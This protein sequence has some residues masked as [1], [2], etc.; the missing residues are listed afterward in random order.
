MLEAAPVE[1]NQV[2]FK[3]FLSMHLSSANIAALWGTEN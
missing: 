2:H 3:L 1:G